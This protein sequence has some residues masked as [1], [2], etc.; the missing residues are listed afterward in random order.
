MVLSGNTS[1]SN[2]STS[3]SFPIRKS[4]GCGYSSRS[5]QVFALS[6]L[7]TSPSLHPPGRRPVALLQL[8]PLPP[9]STPSAGTLLLPSCCQSSV[10]IQK[11]ASVAPVLLAVANAALAYPPATSRQSC[12]HTPSY[13]AI[14]H[15]FLPRH[16]SRV[17][18]HTLTS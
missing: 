6:F 10:A 14:G 2:F 11:P 9:L 1:V 7:L 4:I 17:Q 5:S 3:A 15:R 13:P 12:L 16:R 18:V 8:H